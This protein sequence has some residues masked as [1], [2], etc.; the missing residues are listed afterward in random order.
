MTGGLSRRPAAK[1]ATRDVPRA[2]IA[3]RDRRTIT[4]IAHRQTQIFDFAPDFRRGPLAVLERVAA[5]Q[6][7]NRREDGW[8][9]RPSDHPGWTP[10]QAYGSLRAAARRSGLPVTVSRLPEGIVI[11]TELVKPVSHVD[12]GILMM[13]AK[14]GIHPREF[15]YDVPGWPEPRENGDAGAGARNGATDNEAETP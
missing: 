14:D 12:F 7:G 5:L 4:D 15:G 9:L 8:L 3:P 11:R 2:A 1:E 10:L 13:C 6:F